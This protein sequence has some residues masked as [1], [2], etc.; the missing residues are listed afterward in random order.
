M[1]RQGEDRPGAAGRDD[2]PARRRA[3]GAAEAGPR[4]GHRQRRRVLQRE[5]RRRRRL[6]Q[7]I[8][9]VAG[10]FLI[11]SVY[12]AV[13]RLLLSER[14]PAEE[15]TDATGDPGKPGSVLVA[16]E[17]ADGVRAAVLL[18]TDS[19]PHLV[20]GLPAKTLLQGHAGFEA[21]DDL[22]QRGGYEAVAP[23]LESLLGVRPA[24][25]AA[26]AWPALRAA[27]DKAGVEGEWPDA[28]QGGAE[29][30]QTA[31]LALAG[32]A[33]GGQ[34]AL[35]AWKDTDV[36]GD[37]EAARAALASLEPAEEQTRLL[38]GKLVEGVDFVYFEP[39][40][41]AL[42]D[43]LGAPGPRRNVEV[44]VQN[45]SGV[46]RIA[47]DV[48]E[49]IAPLGYNLLP[50]KNAEGF[51]DVELTLIYAARNVLAEADRVRGVLGLGRVLPEDSLPAG[52][53]VVVVGK[54]LT[55]EKLEQA[56]ARG[57]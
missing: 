28:L 12:L 48:G 56:G 7:A 13:D 57:G 21:L 11:A 2:R 31:A 51:P 54:D 19:S 29:D 40:V 3:A 37:G 1:T 49:A 38:P 36:Q 39:D 14:G 32:L 25:F 43:I 8:V 6:R 16:V 4:R 53:V 55:P 22:L 35:E 41:L 47:E 23:G 10:L 26:V 42:E 24:G 46:V 50:A 30:A 17:G 9:L 52:R 27:L 18:R 5:R 45:G 15:A 44:E 33:A 20:L 34:K